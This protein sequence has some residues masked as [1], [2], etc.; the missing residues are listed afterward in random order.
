MNTISPI[1]LLV[2]GGAALYLGLEAKKAR[3]RSAAAPSTPAPSPTPSPI[4][5]CDISTDS[6]PPGS[7]C[8]PLYG[9]GAAPPGGAD[10][11]VCVEES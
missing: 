5:Y 9:E 7:S 2:A 10:M 4:V 8:V 11:G 1:L 3:E 6:C